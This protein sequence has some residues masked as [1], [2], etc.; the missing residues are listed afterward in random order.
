MTVEL[1]DDD[2]VDHAIAYLKQ[3]VR[4]ALDIE[5]NSVVEEIDPFTDLTK[6]S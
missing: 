1:N 2:V 3:S 5:D 6:Q 4:R